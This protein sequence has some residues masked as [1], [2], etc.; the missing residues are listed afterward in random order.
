M[1]TEI[2][3]DPITSVASFSKAIGKLKSGDTAIVV[4]Q[5]GERSAI[6]EMRID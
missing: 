2:D 4:V 6:I 3:G 5:R 1:I